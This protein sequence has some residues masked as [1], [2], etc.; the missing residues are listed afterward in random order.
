MNRFALSPFPPLSE[1]NT[2]NGGDSRSNTWIFEA[3]E[4]GYYGLKGSADNMGRVVITD[5]NTNKLK[6]IA[7]TPNYEQQAG[8]SAIHRYT[9]RRYWYII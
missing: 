9:R 5:Y 2:D 3:Q 8:D 4:T 6:S 7:E 1:E